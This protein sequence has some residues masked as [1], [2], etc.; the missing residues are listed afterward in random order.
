MADDKILNRVQKLLDLANHPNTGAAERDAAIASADRLMIKHAIDEAM[1]NATLSR[2]ERRKPVKSVFHAADANLWYWEKFRTVLYC[3]AEAHDVRSAF[4][5]GGDVTLVGFHEDVEYVKMKWLNVFLHFTKTIDPVWDNSLTVDHNVYNFKTAGKRWDV[6]QDVA[7]Q[8][9]HDKPHHFFKPSYR[10]HCKLIGEEP[11]PHTQ[12][13]MAYRESF[14]EAFV[15]RILARIEE[16]TQERSKAVVEAGALVHVKDASSQIDDLFYEMFPGLRPLTEEQIA[17][18]RRN[19]EEARRLE[20]ERI[21]KM[22]PDERRAYE[23]EQ[24]QERRRRAR[25]DARYYREQDKLY[26]AEGANL[27]R[28]SADKVDLN[29]MDGMSAADRKEL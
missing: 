6:I 20:A 28:A 8:N 22:S 9:G 10:R 27:G 13:N 4:H 16:M 12:R 24:E 21:A 18:I 11:R 3:I 14:T 2:S 7:R 5:W 19:R 15:R 26:D 29:R 1:L 23:R 25:E 17:E